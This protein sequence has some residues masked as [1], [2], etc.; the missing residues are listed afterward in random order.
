MSL[1]TGWLLGVEPVGGEQPDQVVEAK[2]LAALRPQ[3]PQVDQL[4]QAVLGGGQVAPGQDLAAAAAPNEAAG[5][6]ASRRNMVRA[7]PVSWAYDAANA[8]STPLPGGLSV[9][10]RRLASDSS[11]TSPA[12]YRSGW[13]AS[14]VPAACSASG[15]CPQSRATVST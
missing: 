11:A 13:P 15:R 7:G 14:Q 8:A 6:W 2:P 5:T 12:I 9:A 1:P 4:L 10:R 3:Q